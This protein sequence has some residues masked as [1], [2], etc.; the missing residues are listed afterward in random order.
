VPPLVAARR[1]A[2]RVLVTLNGRHGDDPS[3][4]VHERHLRMLRAAGLLPVLVTGTAPADEVAELASLCDCA[5][6]PGTDHVPTRLG[7][8]AETSA[9]GAREAGL[10]WDP[11][12]VAADLAV[13]AVAW[14][15]RLPLLGVCGGMQAMAIRGGGTLRPGTGEELAAHEDVRGGGRVALDDG[16]L[17]AEVLGRE[18]EV[19][20]VHRQVVAEPPPALRITGHAPDGVAEAIEADRAEHPFWL[21]LQWHPELLH[22]ARPYGAL[23]AAALR[24]GDGGRATGR[25][26][27]S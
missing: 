15:E 20:S 27:R 9:R 11:W 13:L 3:H 21:G 25:A 12:K 2:A 8:D 26:R 14:T 6:L 19:N 4:E 1:R 18:T 24:G 16:S 5:Y 23:A 17:A 7:E 22:D 10:P